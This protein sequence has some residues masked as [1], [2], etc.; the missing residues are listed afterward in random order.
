MIYEQD[1]S[2]QQFFLP[3][4]VAFV[5]LLRGVN[6]FQPLNKDFQAFINKLDTQGSG[7]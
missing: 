1:M 2:L 7:Q 4:I 5:A 6:W 3:W